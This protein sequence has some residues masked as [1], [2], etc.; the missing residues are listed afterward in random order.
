MGCA[1]KKGIRNDV[2]L[3]PVQLKLS[4]STMLKSTKEV[5]L[6][7]GTTRSVVHMTHWDTF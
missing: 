4:I 3:W 2:R 7:G 5:S 1:R 6:R